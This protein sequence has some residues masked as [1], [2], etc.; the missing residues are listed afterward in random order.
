VQFTTAEEPNAVR[1]AIDVYTR[2]SNFFDLFAVRTVGA[3]AQS[4]NWRAVVQRMVDLSGGTSGGV[5][6]EVEKLEEEDAAKVEKSVRR[7]VQHRQ[8]DE[9]PSAENAPQR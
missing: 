4:A 7:M 9:S 6:T 8:R 5:H 2:A 3:P 1:F